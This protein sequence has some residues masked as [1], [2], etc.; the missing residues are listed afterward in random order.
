[1]TCGLLA[2]DCAGDGVAVRLV[3]GALATV[4]PARIAQVSVAKVNVRN[5]GRRRT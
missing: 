5:N 3:L 2:G 1:V 4:Q